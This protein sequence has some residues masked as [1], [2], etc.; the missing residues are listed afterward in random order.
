MPIANIA[1]QNI[2][3]DTEFMLDVN[4]TGNPTQ[5]WIEGLLEGFHTDWDA[6]TLRVRGTA[7]RLISNTPFT[8]RN[9]N[10][11]SRS[12]TFSVNPAAPVITNPGRQTLYRGIE[13][14]FIVEIANSPSIVRAAGP[15]I[16]M[17][18]EPHPQGIRIFGDVPASTDAAISIPG[19]QRSIRVTAE[20]G[21][22]TDTLDVAFD[23]SDAVFAYILESIDRRIYYVRFLPADGQAATIVEWYNLPTG[24]IQPIGLARGNGNFYVP[25]RTDRS[26]YV[27]PENIENEGTPE[28]ADVRR[29]DMPALPRF[30]AMS[31]ALLDGNS[32]IVYMSDISNAAYR[33]YYV[34]PENTAHDTTAVAT[35]RLRNPGN[36]PNTST[37][38]TIIGNEFYYSDIRLNPDVI[39]VF[40][41]NTADDVEATEIRRMNYTPSSIGTITGMTPFNNRLM[42]VDSR[43]D[44]IKIIRTTPD[45]DGNVQIDATITLPSE[46]NFPAGIAT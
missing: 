2:T 9:S 4:I 31:G 1:H 21:Q 24:L 36:P 39:V 40:D 44:T 22:L 11:E 25:K 32:L 34:V 37:K 15:W 29:F 27:F 45:S 3:I 30:S 18:Y 20:T 35:K 42:I 6:P 43:Y 19:T 17:K 14:E 33:R 5:A 41:K 7:T 8:V 16:G 12:A 26:V 28:T 13:N 10:G 23:I 46:I 38:F